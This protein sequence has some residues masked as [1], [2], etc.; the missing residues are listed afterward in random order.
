MKNL[1]NVKLNGLSE[2]QVIKA[3]TEHFKKCDVL[4][5]HYSRRTNKLHVTEFDG[6][7]VTQWQINDF[8][9]VIDNEPQFNF[10]HM[11]IIKIIG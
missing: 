11:N 3:V 9:C 8:I 4:A 1:M 10:E 6:I 5:I 2:S 7:G